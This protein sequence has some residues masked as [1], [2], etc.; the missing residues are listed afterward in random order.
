V[1]RR[2]F[3]SVDQSA[4]AMLTRIDPVF[5]SDHAV[6]RLASRPTTEAPAESQVAGLRGSRRFSREAATNLCDI[7]DLM[8]DEA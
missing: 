6:P 2:R 8:I 1:F 3:S 4:L 7:S 5:S